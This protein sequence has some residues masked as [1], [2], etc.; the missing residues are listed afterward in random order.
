MKTDR[1][2]TFVILFWITSFDVFGQVQLTSSSR[3]QVEPYIAVN[4]TD[5][6]NV[7][8]A[9]ISRYGVIGSGST[10]NQISVF[11]STNLGSSWTVSDPL[12]GNV[13][14]NDPTVA[15]DADGN[16]YLL[17]QEDLPGSSLYI[18]KS[19]DGGVTWGGRVLVQQGNTSVNR[20]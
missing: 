11:Y 14:G 9:V 19:T 17:Y 8:G 16:C 7:V 6:T 3:N 18:H 10:R 13:Y 4:P 15:F 2:F 1:F 5:Y 20:H 12:N